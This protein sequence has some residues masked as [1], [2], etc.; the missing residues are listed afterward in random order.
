MRWLVILA[1]VACSKSDDKPAETKVEKP[2]HHEDRHDPAQAPALA[3]AVTT[4]GATTTWG[5][6][7]FAVVPKLAGAAS[8]GEAR[9]TW[10]LRELVHAHVGATARVTA[11]KSAD[12]TRAI[13]EA[14]WND[15]ARTPI[16]HTT[17][18]GTL[19]FRW[20]DKD[21]AWGETVLKDVTGLDVAN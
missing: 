21:G 9:D 16:L 20:A 2:H 19:K 14:E 17:R 3:L 11:V 15:A 6:D 7:R 13:S 5:A 12:A 1:L 18:R 4:G 10:S 8:D